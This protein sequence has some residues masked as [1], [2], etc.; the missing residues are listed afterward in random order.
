MN[1]NETTISREQLNFLNEAKIAF[2]FLENYNYKIVKEDITFLRYEVNFV[3]I[4]IFHGRISYEIGIEIGC[5]KNV[6][7]ETIYPIEYLI[8]MLDEIAAK[9]YFRPSGNTKETIRNCLNTQAQLLKN[10]G[11]RVFHGDTTIWDE[12]ETYK[13]KKIN[14]YWKKMKINDFREKANSAFREKRYNDFIKLFSTYEI[15]LTELERK[16]LEFARSRANGEDYT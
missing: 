7:N 4:N 6:E 8:G 14:E 11:D 2:K 16:K 9:R 10:Y 5:H 15:Q 3:F 1:I 12:L 13:N